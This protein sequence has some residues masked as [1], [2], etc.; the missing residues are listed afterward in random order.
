MNIKLNNLFNGLVESRLSRFWTATIIV[1]AVA[2][3]S[4]ITARAVTFLS[5]A[6]FG[7]FSYGSI[8]QAE[9]TDG[10]PESKLWF[11]DGLW[12]G[13]LYNPVDNEYQIFHLDWNSQN[14][15]TT[16][17]TTDVR[18]DSRADVLWDGVNSKLYVLSHVKEENPSQ[19]NN[20]ENWARLYRYSYDAVADT[21]SLDVDFDPGVSVNED[22]TRTVVLDKDST[23]R[24]WV[25]YVSREIGSSTYQVYV[26]YTTTSNEDDIWGTPYALSF[27]E[28]TV[29]LDAISSV[30]AFTDE[31]GP[32]V[33]VA[34]SN[35]LANEFGDKFYFATHL[36]SENPDTGWEL[37]TEFTDA[38]TYPANNHL[39][40]AK[41]PNGQLFFAIKTMATEPGQPLI[42]LVARDTD[43]SY[44][45]RSVSPVGSNDTRPIVIY[46]A[47]SND[48]GDE[49]LYVFT[50]SN[51]TGGVVCYVRALVTDPLSGMTF[52]P[53]NCSV[54]GG[55]ATATRVLADTTL[56]SFISDVTSTKQGLTNDT[57]IV[58]LA[59][60]DTQKTYV[61]AVLITQF[62]Y[63][64]SVL[65]PPDSMVPDLN[66]TIQAIF[67]EDMD[68]ATINT[69][70][71]TLENSVGLVAGIVNYDGFTHQ[72]DFDPDA[73]L[74]EGEIYT[75]TLTAD[76][77]NPAGQPLLNSPYS[78]SFRTPA[79]PGAFDKSS[80]S[81]GATDVSV[82]PTLTWGSSSGA[83]SY[84]YCYDTSNDDACTPWVDNGTATIV[85]LS[86]LIPST[87]YYWH[88]RAN[89]SHGTTYS[90]GS[91]TA[92]W[93]FTTG[94]V[95]GAFV[96][97]APA[98][99]ATGQPL[100]PTLSWGASSGATSYEYCYDTSNDDACTLWVDNGTATNVGLS[101]LIPSTT[102]YWHVR[103]NNSHGMTYSNGSETAFWSFTTGSVPGAFVKIAPTDGATGLPLNPTL[104]WGSS[105]GATSYEYCYDTSND[106]A[107]TPWVDN[108]TATSVGLSG[109][110]PS[111][112][113]Y[114]HVRAVNSF[115]TTYS[116]GSETAFWSFTTGNIPGAFEKTA[117]TDGATGQP[118]N[119]ILTWGSSS[120]ATRYEYC[121]DTSNDNACTPWVDNGI[122][123]DVGLSGLIP[124][125][126]YY[127]H[128]RAINSIGTTY[129]NGSEIAFWSFTTGNIPGA[130]EKT[131]PA[132]GSTGQPLNPTLTWGSSA[133]ATLYEYCYDTTND[134][135]CSGWTGV[136]SNTSVEL[137]GLEENTFYY[138]HVRAANSE[139]ITYSDGLDTDF[140][141]FNTTA[142]SIRTFLP[143]IVK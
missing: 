13:N 9:P 109:L 14:W 59:A 28:A 53:A 35:E 47:G 91:E 63:V 75:A 23:G 117:P 130:F 81:N 142:I 34:W 22:R 103:A 70:S 122:A 69:S 73:D 51:P 6:G 24:L 127:W 113:Y 106:D 36:D 16:G 119:P 121:Y 56:Y 60:D 41:S 29:N 54:D 108:G 104:T 25:T 31:E 99:G 94:S 134:N 57:D 17:V 43:G 38:I 129:S 114:W 8:V 10:R 20:P 120:G 50:V 90:N 45:F 98:N 11:N 115:G 42:A 74:V 49:Y 101:G 139:G 107:C 21:Y 96:K 93:S 12:W 44:Y 7:D 4:V 80:P 55:P 76:V 5:V 48:P 83:T 27:P 78:W 133:G 32:K 87:T 30:I 77:T 140:W 95:P 18:P 15:V 100:N 88:V 84:E 1:V 26:N 141:S 86:G 136:G 89:N 137:S 2:L 111:T 118:L 126:T 123:T 46:Y 125:T 128:V 110:I 40:I 92:F 72:A 112:T 67:S 131:A 102:Y 143:M 85:G 68:G 64:T 116:N 132:N 82:S 33:G 105:S 65:P 61:H 58:V 135:A 138:W 62:P 79:P 124:S 52:T 19:T 97:M 3:L 71:F 39:N 37:Q 66:P